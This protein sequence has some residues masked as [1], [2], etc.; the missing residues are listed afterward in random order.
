MKECIYSALQYIGP[1]SDDFYGT[2][3]PFNCMA[4]SVCPK[5]S[6]SSPKLSN[7]DYPDSKQ[8]IKER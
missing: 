8:K 3:C 2:N 1:T 4:S 7:G 6:P 5:Y